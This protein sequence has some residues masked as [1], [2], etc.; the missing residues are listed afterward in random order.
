MTVGVLL[1]SL[2]LPFTLALMPL[3]LA[4]LQRLDVHDLPST[5]SSHDAP[6]LRGGGIAPALAA[7]I[8][9]VV[10]SRRVDP[11]LLAL[12]LA[13][14]LL[15]LIGMAE[16]IRGMSPL[17]RLAL[18]L[19]A[20]AVAAAGLAYFSPLGLSASTT[21]LLFGAAVS[22]WLVSFTNAFN[23]MDG[24]N[25]ISG[26]HAL[27]IGLT[28][29]TTGLTLDV[30]QAVF[31][32]GVVAGAAA[33]FLPYNF[34]RAKGFLG[35]VGSYFFGGWIAVAAVLLFGAIPTAV[36]L[37]PLLP[38]AADTS[39]TLVRRVRRGDNWHEAHR[40]H[41]YQRVVSAGW[42]H[43][44]TATLVGGL[45]LLCGLLGLVAG[46]IISESQVMAVAALLAIG[47]VL[48][49]YLAL[50]ERLERPRDR[51]PSVS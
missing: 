1:A 13:G 47:V 34:P 27:A 49:G 14:G 26:L 20:T 30:Q 3:A 17:Q 12:A 10:A 35:D 6:V 44:A 7:V 2:T 16:D 40:E 25:G 29:V 43:T 46:G 11:S 24:I 45:T 21:Q 8:V 15:A 51:R 42:G 4:L 33:A 19:V 28:W 36:V 32:G 22:L 18:Q 31:V 9:A 50:P 38:Y 39:F 23:F 5:R 37:A 48:A 41:V